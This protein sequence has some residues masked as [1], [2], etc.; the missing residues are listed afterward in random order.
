MNI[1]RTKKAI[2]KAFKAQIA[3]KGFALVEILSPCPTNWKMSPVEAHKW[4]G[5]IMTNQFPLKVIKDELGE[6]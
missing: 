2:K 4:V 5:E 1:K 3:N 6:L